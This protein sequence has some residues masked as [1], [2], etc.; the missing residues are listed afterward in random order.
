MAARIH[1]SILSWGDDMRFY[2]EFDENGKLIAVGEG[3]ALN[4]VDITKEEYEELLA[5][6][7]QAGVY[8]EMIYRGEST[9]DEVPEEWRETVQENVNWFVAE[10]GPYDPDEISDEEAMDIIT[11][12]VG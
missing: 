8:A 3:D 10:L 11:G 2:K 1:T 6:I 7:E 4:G 12:V 5:Q 9:M